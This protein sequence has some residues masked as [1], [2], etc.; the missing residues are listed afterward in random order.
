MHSGWAREVVRFGW[1]AIAAIGTA[2]CTPDAQTSGTAGA[3]GTSATS[4]TG[5]K[6]TS[7]TSTTSS[8]ANSSTS[9]SMCVPDCSTS[10]CGPDGCN[11][12]CGECTATDAC[13]GG[14]CDTVVWGGTAF[15]PMDRITTSGTSLLVAERSGS[16][17]RLDRHGLVLGKSTS[18]AGL[19]RV[20]TDDGPIEIMSESGAPPMLRSL[21][22]VD[23][24]TFAVTPGP[25][26]GGPTD[27]T[28]RRGVKLN[29][30]MLAVGDQATGTNIPFVWR[31]DAGNDCSGPIT[32]L[33]GSAQANAIATDGTNFWIGMTS[34][35]PNVSTL[36]CSAG[37]ACAASVLTGA[38]AGDLAIRGMTFANGSLYVAGFGLSTYQAHA[39]RLSPQT[40]EIEG[41][42]PLDL[43]P[44]YEVFRAVAANTTHVFFV[45]QKNYESTG[46]SGDGMVYRLPANFADCTGGAVFDVPNS[47]NVEDVALL[48][49]LV[50][51]GGTLKGG[52][53]FVASCSADSGLCPSTYLSLPQ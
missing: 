19:P 48:P 4:T 17:R 13:V 18:I 42:C 1:V 53:G 5:S 26:V 8:S 7:T 21:A 39:Y 49:G 15:G 32:W 47:F 46:G 6:T 24:S 35:P 3:G 2:A 27:A 43:T 23:A 52:A 28:V 30:G 33:N 40:G 20:L 14:Q 22:F 31:H 45:G 11:G 25:T 16:V 38:F 34:T 41:H 51:L 10:K 29:Q 12:S 36:A 50:A 37:C 9:T 44:N